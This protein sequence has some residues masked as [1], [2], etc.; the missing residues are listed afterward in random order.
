MIYT[1]TL[2]PAVDKTLMVPGFKAGSVNRVSFSKTDAGGKGINVSQVIKGFGID[3][4][5]MGIAGGRNGKMITDAVES[6]GIKTDFVTVDGETRVNTKIVDTERRTTT[7]VNEAGCCVSS[8]DLDELLQRLAGKIV[9]GDIVVIAG[10]LPQGASDDTYGVWTKKCGELG[11]KV[12]LDTS[13]EGMKKALE[14]KPYFIKPNEK[15]LEEI[16]G[17]ELPELRDICKAAKELVEKGIKKVAVSMGGDGVLLATAEKMLYAPGIEVEV[18]TTVGA[19]D[20]VVAAFAVAEAEGLDEWDALMLAV[21]S[22]TAAVMKS[23]SEP[24]DVAD[25][26]YLVDTVK[27]RKI[28]AEI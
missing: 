20:A 9:Q 7:D 18:N 21:A 15:E 1:I 2:N 14:N 8:G 28:V 12:F 13:G 11:A 16:V 5:A 19:G 24:A 10:S 22:G 17:R 3:N 4:M 27:V 26:L 6:M 23:G 25:I